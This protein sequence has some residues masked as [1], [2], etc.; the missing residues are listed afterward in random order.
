MSKTRKAS[1]ILTI[2]GLPESIS[3]W[4]QSTVH[5]LYV[6]GKDKANIANGSAY[7]ASNSHH[8]KG[9]AKKVTQYATDEKMTKLVDDGYTT[10]RN[11]QVGLKYNGSMLRWMDNKLSDSQKILIDEL[12]GFETL[13]KGDDLIDRMV[14]LIEVTLNAQNVR[15]SLDDFDTFAKDLNH[16]TMLAC[17]VTANKIAGTFEKDAAVKVVKPRKYGA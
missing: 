6:D 12:R 13:C 9:Q 11:R 16:R 17:Q 4:S 1:D 14:K 3:L 8:D 5:P 15:I 2:E 10:D 7:A